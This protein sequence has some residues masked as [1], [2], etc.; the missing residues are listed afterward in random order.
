[1]EQLE[2]S[3]KYKQWKATL[4]QNKVDLVHLEERC[5]IRK[6][7]GEVLFSMIEIDAKA[8]DGEKIL[9][10]A[11]LRGHFVSVLVVFIDKTTKER[12]VLLVKQYR[13]ANG[14]ICY[15]FAAGMC[16]NDADPFAVA[17][18]E[19]KEETGFVVGR[20]QL[21]LMNE[22]LIYSSPGLLDEGGYLF[23]CEI[24][25]THEQM[26]E[27]QH[28]KAGAVDESEFILTEV[29]PIG[30]VL[31]LVNSMTSVAQLLW[32]ARLREVKI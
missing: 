3:L 12:H 27:F 5:T 17:M 10:I 1:M 19:V 22:E 20:E 18:K 9:P 7:N 4:D 14:A 6:P 2:N 16:D 23:W 31:S 28:K 30:R 21:N 29:V 13:V 15:E 32:Y 11:L 8:A 24:E 25:L 26:Q